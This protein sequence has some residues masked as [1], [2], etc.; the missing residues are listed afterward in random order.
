MAD[1]ETVERSASL[2]AAR[3]GVGGAS[4]VAARPAAPRLERFTSETVAAL[5]WWTPAL[6]SFRTTR[7]RSFRF[8]PGH[9][10]RLG[11]ERADGAVVWRPFS[12]ASAAWD[13]RLEFF[14]VLVEGGEFSGLLASIREGDRILVEKA[15]YGFMTVD[16]FA[17]G[18]DLWMIASGTGLGPYLSILRDPRNWQDF[19]RLIVV[20]SV[21]RCPDL[22]YRDAIEAMPDGEALADARAKLRY[23][24]VVTRE[25]CDGALPARI[26]ELVADGRLEDA[27]GVR[28]DP[29]HSRIMVCGNPG[30]ARELRRQFTARGFAPNRRAA[31]GQLAFENY[32][33]GTPT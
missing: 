31:P 32:W 10:A 19:E 33:Q 27:A 9:Y 4:A 3:N 15:S 26:P 29:V 25:A 11:L 18:R 30:L 14:A 24:P 21:R 5:H 13:E 22:A 6:L 20:H 1:V 28:F 7:A 8:T 16:Q 17:P 12:V 23:V 2:E